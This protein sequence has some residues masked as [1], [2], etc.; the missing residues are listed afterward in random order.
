MEE[1]HL[2]S[3]NQKK[4]MKGEEMTTSKSKSK[5]SSFS[6]VKNLYNLLACFGNIF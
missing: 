2:G 5:T 1:T 3:S 6:C 4:Y